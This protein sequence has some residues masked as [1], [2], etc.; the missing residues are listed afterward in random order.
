MVESDEVRRS[1]DTG[2]VKKMVYSL[3]GK[4]GYLKSSQGAESVLG[5]AKQGLQ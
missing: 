1:N 4:P 2:K 3:T 5:I